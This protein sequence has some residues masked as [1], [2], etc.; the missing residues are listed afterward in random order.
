MKVGKEYGKPSVGCFNSSLCGKSGGF[1]HLLSDRTCA[2]QCC[3]VGPGTETEYG[4]VI[5]AGAG[6]GG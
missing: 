4:G 5:C 2:A 3:P 6:V 1:F